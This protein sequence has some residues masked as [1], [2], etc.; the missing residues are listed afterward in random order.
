MHNVG[1]WPHAADK[2]KAEPVTGASPKLM[3]RMGSAWLTSAVHC[4][5][6]A[7]STPARVEE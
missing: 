4:S 1:Q 5:L 2:A 6:P 3:A 7:L